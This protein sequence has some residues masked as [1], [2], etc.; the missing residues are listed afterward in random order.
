[1][2]QVEQKIA[3]TLSSVLRSIFL[4]AKNRGFDLISTTWCGENARDRNVFDHKLRVITNSPLFAEG[5]YFQPTYRSFSFHSKLFHPTLRTKKLRIFSTKQDFF[6]LPNQKNGRTPASRG[7]GLV[8]LWLL[9]PQKTGDSELGKSSIF[10]LQ[11]LVVF[12][13]PS[14]HTWIRLIA[15]SV[16]SSWL[17]M[18]HVFRLGSNN[19]E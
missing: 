5:T 9:G 7:S 10:R 18:F 19:L 12:G 15:R 4:N 8:L 3:L 2:V 16:P 13:V 6:W 14:T 17:W 1:M 11:P